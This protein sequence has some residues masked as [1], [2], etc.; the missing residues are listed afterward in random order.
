MVG[1]LEK[2]GM[3]GPENRGWESKIFLAKN[4][5]KPFLTKYD[6]YRPLDIDSLVAM[7]SPGRQ[8]VIYICIMQSYHIPHYL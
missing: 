4:L 2:V 5:G 3:L 7:P 6:D 1:M 8:L